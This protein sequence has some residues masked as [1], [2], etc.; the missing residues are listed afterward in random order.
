MNISKKHGNS[1]P[2]A[3]LAIFSVVNLLFMHYTIVTSCGL[4]ENLIYA[5]YGNIVGIAFDTT[6]LITLFGIIFRRHSRRA[7]LA[8]Y[9]TTLAW[10]FANV[11]YSRFFGQYIS[12]SA[13]RQAG[14]LTD[15]LMLQCMYERLRITDLYY[16]LSA[17]AFAIAYRRMGDTLPT[18]RTV[19]AAWAVT[20]VIFVADL[21]LNVA[22]CCASPATRYVSYYKH[23][24]C[25]KY[26]DNL[27]YE[28]TLANFIRGSFGTLVPDAYANMHFFR[29]LTSD[30]T[31][32]IE[33]DYTDYTHRQTP[34][35]ICLAKPDNIVFIIVESYLAVSSGLHAGG[36]EVT[37]C[38]NA[39]RHD[40]TVYYN[41]RMQPDIRIGESSDGQFI[42]MAG[43]L[44]LR[45]GITVNK[46]K[47]VSL[48]GLPRMLAGRI[49]GITSKMIIPTVPTYWDQKDMCDAY[50]FDSLYS[51]ND[52]PSGATTLT[53]ADVFDMAMRTDS[54]T[55]QPF[56]SVVLTLSM[57]QPY[58]N[59]IETDDII[60]DPALPAKY[61][62]YLTACRYTD[63][64][65]GRYIDHLKRTG[66]YDRTLII[67][68]ADHHAHPDLLDMEGKVTEDL[69][70]FIINGG[71]NTAKA[72]SGECRQLDVYTTLL[73]LLGIESHWRGL[74]HTLLCPAYTPS[75]T[76]E[77]EELSEMIVRGNYFGSHDF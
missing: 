44:P 32:R 49:P 38:L 18:L 68:T 57:H 59:R 31:V 15:G 76:A 27:E 22:Y 65:I 9:V 61:N 50:G 35:S 4:E 5:Y 42:Y 7:L 37:P 12:V 36:K 75:A 74:G 56:F 25:K 62:N 72:Y 3:I 73:D 28:L 54:M 16:P 51:A 66:L 60:D 23:V 29:P 14:V 34:D 64:Q 10:A 77:R 58:Y 45:N 47:Q 2:T 11:L 30:E 55:R 40:S 69:P 71:I 46:A 24:L 53:D 43:L 19:A 70:L 33:T 8:C 41:G 17:A 39:L 1:L 21:L 26:T 20:G 63:K 13:I 6:L 67:I 52:F 48:P